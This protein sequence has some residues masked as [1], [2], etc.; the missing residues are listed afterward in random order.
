MSLFDDLGCPRYS[1]QYNFTFFSFS[2]FRKIKYA[3]KELTEIS[4]KEL[5]S[6]QVTR[7]ADLMGLQFSVKAKQDGHRTEIIS[8]EGKDI[9][10]VSGIFEDLFNIIRNQLNFTFSLNI[11]EDNNNIIIIYFSKQQ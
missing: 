4:L 11:P 7:R 10:K 2:F 8:E 3:R 6:K 9:A 5:A 1:I